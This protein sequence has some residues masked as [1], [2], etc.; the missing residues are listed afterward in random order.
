M[1]IRQTVWLLPAK[2]IE[3]STRFGPTLMRSMIFVRLTNPK[4]CNIDQV[5]WYLNIFEKKKYKNSLNHNEYISGD[6][7]YKILSNNMRNNSLIF[8]KQ[9]QI[10][11]E[12]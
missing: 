6:K 3:V 9:H 5:F 4:I 12:N 1:D 7:I 2:D 11:S 10:K 8:F